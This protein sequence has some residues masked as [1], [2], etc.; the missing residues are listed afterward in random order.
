VLTAGTVEFLINKNFAMTAPKN[1][2]NTIWGIHAGKTG[3]A[4]SLFTEKNV[5][6]I[7]W[8]EVGDLSKLPSDWDKLKKRVADT[9]PD[10]KP[11]AIPVFAGQLWR[12][13]KEVAEG[14]LVVYPSKAQNKIFLGAIKGPYTYQ[15]KTN[16]AYPNMR[17][18]KWI[19]E[20]SRTSFTQGALYEAGAAMSLFQ[21]KNYA[22]E[23]RSALEGKH[24]TLEP[25]TNDPT[26]AMVAEEVEQTTRDFILKRLSQDLK[27]LPLED[28]I[29]NL[30]QAM[31]YYARLTKKN[32]PSI[33]VIAHKDRLGIEPPIIKVQ[34]KSGDGNVTDRDVSA[35]YGKLSSHGE[36]GLFITLASFSKEARKFEETKSNLRLVD[37]NELVDLVL[38]HYDRFEARVKGIVPLRRVYMPEGA[39]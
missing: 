26:V 12:F 37:G 38:Q 5:M 9:Y 29:V 23:F 11:G 1:S 22:E 28:F 34:V 7:G 32:E 39:E 33:D 27:G 15:P 14:D 36:T 6:A 20:F 25:V 18:V 10:A 4:D 35:L 24:K 16:A 31:G 19:K 2:E 3:D 8:P 21:I 13:A 17:A 30:L